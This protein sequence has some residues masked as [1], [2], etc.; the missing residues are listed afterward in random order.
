[1]CLVP[2]FGVAEA[3][4]ARPAKVRLWRDAGYS[5]NRSSGVCERALTET[6]PTRSVCVRGVLQRDGLCWYSA[7]ETKTRPQVPG[8]LS[9][10]G[11]G[12]LS[13]S[14]CKRSYERVWLRTICGASATGTAVGSRRVH[15]KAAR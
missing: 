9:C 7:L 8:A 14:L 5:L 10:P 13:G 6:P 15:T 1:M 11:G 3:Q 12:T 2:G 4:S